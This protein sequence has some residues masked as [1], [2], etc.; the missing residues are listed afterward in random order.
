MVLGFSE[1]CAEMVLSFAEL[2]AQ[3]L[4]VFFVDLSAHLPLEQLGVGGKPAGDRFQNG[5]ECGG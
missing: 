1:F 4:D 2:R 3:V 5:S